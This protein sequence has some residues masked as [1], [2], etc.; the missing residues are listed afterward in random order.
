MS[1]GTIFIH[2]GKKHKDDEIIFGVQ[3]SEVLFS[4]IEKIHQEHSDETVQDTIEN[5]I[6]VYNAY[7]KKREDI[8]KYRGEL[9]E[10]KKKAV[11]DIQEELRIDMQI[12]TIDYCLGE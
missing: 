2:D 1:K 9:V 11:D 4:K 8:L 3:M 10:D 12:E 7:G 5:I 6:D